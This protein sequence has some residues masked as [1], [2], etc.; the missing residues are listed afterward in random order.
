MP[1]DFKNNSNDAGI[2]PMHNSIEQ[3]QGSN[4][5][6]K[7]NLNMLLKLYDCIFAPFV[8]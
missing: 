6:S 5:Y 4:E 3:G 2:M 7:P 8:C 1:A